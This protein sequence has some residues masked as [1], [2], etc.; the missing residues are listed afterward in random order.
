MKAGR[1]HKVVKLSLS[2][3]NKNGTNK[4]RKGKTEESRTSQT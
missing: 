3:K 4:R 2:S 1:L